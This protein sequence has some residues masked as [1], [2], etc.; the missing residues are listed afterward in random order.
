MKPK[1]ARNV[2]GA[3]ALAVADEIVRAANE[4]APEAGPAASALALIGHEPG[5]SIRMLSA[6][7]GLSHAGAVRLVD[8]LET[9]GLVER[10]LQATDG[11]TRSLHLT[12]SGEAASAAVLEARDGVLSRG[13]AALSPQELST[14]GELAEKMLRA[15]LRDEAHAYRICRL[16]Q[17]SE[18]RQCP[19]E[20]ELRCR[21]PAAD[22]APGQ[23]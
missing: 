3:I 11:R 21:A 1:R 5:L 14:L 10:R 17:H 16:C 7:V 15:S 9:E 23:P 2:F 12:A 13:L 4:L 22:S 19:V 18:C 6:G 8:R 20:D